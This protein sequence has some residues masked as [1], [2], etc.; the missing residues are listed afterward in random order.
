[1]YL[2]TN[3]CVVFRNFSDTLYIYSHS[4]FSG[5]RNVHSFYSITVVFV[6]FRLSTC[7]VKFL[8][9]LQP[10]VVCFGFLKRDVQFSYQFRLCIRKKIISHAFIKMNCKVALFVTCHFVQFK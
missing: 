8:D 7:A 3:V 4:R 10:T 2:G 1:M 5:Q 6:G 9:Y